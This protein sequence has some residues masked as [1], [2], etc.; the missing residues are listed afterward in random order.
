VDGD[1]C[2]TRQKWLIFPECRKKNSQTLDI[3]ITLHYNIDM[4]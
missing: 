1:Y 2:A 4:S 3:S